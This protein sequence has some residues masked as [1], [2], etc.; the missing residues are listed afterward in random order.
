[1]IPFTWRLLFLFVFDTKPGEP[2]QSTYGS[3]LFFCLSH[4]EIQEC[5]LRGYT[6]LRT[7]RNPSFR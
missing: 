6:T 5:E 4:G 7:N 2:G 1:M 3:H